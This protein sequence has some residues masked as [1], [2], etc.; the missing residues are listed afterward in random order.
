[1]QG[2][3]GPANIIAAALVM[4]FCLSAILTVGTVWIR[5]QESNQ[6]QFY[7]DSPDIGRYASI[8]LV[9]AL[10]TIGLLVFSDQFSDLWRP[11]SGA[12][13]FSIIRWS[14]ALFIVFTLNIICT[15]VLVYLSGGSYRSPFTPV[16]FIL[17]AMAFFL[18]ESMHRVVFYSAAIG[19]V[20]LVTIGTPD[21]DPEHQIVPTGAYLF[22]SLAC[23][24]L[25]V[26]IGYLTRPI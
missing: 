3:V 13:N 23:L 26:V 9:F 16:F 14:H 21:R 1:M 15:A 25:S 12:V 22:V 17:P 6:F 10:I 5:R 8:L 18:R 24:A 20:F 2:T 11:M 7:I 4:Q 19:L